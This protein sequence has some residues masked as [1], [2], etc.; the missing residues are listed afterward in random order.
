MFASLSANP[1][2]SIFLLSRYPRTAV[3]TDTSS[4][5]STPPF[6][7]FGAN[8]ADPN[9]GDYFVVPRLD[10]SSLA[11]LARF[12]V[13]ATAPPNTQPPL[14]HLHH[15]HA[16]SCPHRLCAPRQQIG[17]AGGSGRGTYGGSNPASTTNAP[18]S[19]PRHRSTPSALTT[20][21]PSTPPTT[22]LSPIVR[23]AASSSNL[24]DF[25]P[26]SSFVST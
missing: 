11:H 13:T 3:A 25:P 7:D 24:D 23:V 15:W 6:V 20:V 18:N 10:V 2:C 22:S 16:P 17:A 1:Q 21:R 14:V 8:A 19:A 4:K 12:V 5:A 9:L 26:S